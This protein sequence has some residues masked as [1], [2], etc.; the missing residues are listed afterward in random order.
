M[1]M[2]IYRFDRSKPK[3][4]GILFKSSMIQGI[5]E[6]IKEV[7]RRIVNGEPNE[8]DPDLWHCYAVEKDPELCIT[9]SCEKT[10][11][12]QGTYAEFEFIGMGEHYCN[13]KSRWEI[14]NLLHARETW[15][16]PTLHDGA[17]PDYLYR[18]DGE[19]QRHFGGKWKPGIHMPKKAARIFMMV[20]GLSCE[21][22]SSISAEDCIKEGIE[23][24]F[25]KF[26][27]EGKGGWVYK[28][29]ENDEMLFE[30]P[31]KS[32]RSLWN[33]IHG[34]PEPVFAKGESKP[35]KY[36][37]YPFDEEAATPYVLAQTWR[38]LPL[39]IITNPWVWAIRFRTL[40]KRGRPTSDQ[41]DEFKELWK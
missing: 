4:V 14:G 40:S 32:F 7:T 17:E 11:I 33:K 21:R 24:E 37:V 5:Q 19:I 6:D 8:T 18:A 22:I 31:Y 34:A 23:R 10:R 41:L 12:F 15:A 3:E 38:G 30:D 39:Q 16:E 36:I 1:K 9:K 25:F 20:T 28:N 29:Y 26:I 27:N 35:Y 2:P 13:I